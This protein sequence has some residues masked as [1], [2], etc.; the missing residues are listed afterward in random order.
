[1]NF[2]NIR[3]L[4]NF[5][6]PRY[7]GNPNPEKR[8]TK[9]GFWVALLALVVSI[10]SSITSV[11]FSIKS[12]NSTVAQLKLAQD[13]WDSVK[14][15]HKRNEFS[16]RFKEIQD[17]KKY[18]RDTMRTNQR[19]LFQRQSFDIQQRVN[20][21]QLKAISIQAEVSKKQLINQERI[22]KSNC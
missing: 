17:E 15:E 20:E 9:W 11:I 19:D 8:Y 14:A 1:M 10:G 7:T 18:I 22:T 5:N 3:F 21:K 4:Q 16:S 13:Q 6:S 12:N 2:R